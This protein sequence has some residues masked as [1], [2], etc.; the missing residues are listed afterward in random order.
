M[1]E[2]HEKVWGKEEWI[3]NSPLYCGKILHLK[4]DFECSFHCHKKKTETFYILEGK[5]S[6]KVGDKSGVKADQIMW[7]GE[8]IDIV[9]WSPDPA[10]YV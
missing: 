3:T 6:M 2:T 9:H 1:I 10:K 5:V 7:E 4:K 8:K